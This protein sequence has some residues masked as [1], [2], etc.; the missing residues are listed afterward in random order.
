MWWQSVAKLSC[1]IYAKYYW[2]FL[3]SQILV[4]IDSMAAYV[5]VVQNISLEECVPTESSKENNILPPKIQARK[6][7]IWYD[8]QIPT[9]P[10]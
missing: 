4:P 3:F 6:I 5:S 8:Q 2:Y 7:I 10:H 9:G 1:D